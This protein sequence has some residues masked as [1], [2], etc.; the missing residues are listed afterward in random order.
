MTNTYHRPMVTSSMLSTALPTHTPQYSATPVLDADLEGTDV[1]VRHLDTRDDRQGVKVNING[2]DVFGFHFMLVEHCVNGLD[3]NVLVN[4]TTKAKGIMSNYRLGQW[5]QFDLSEGNSG[6]ALYITSDAG[7]ALPPVT[8]GPYDYT[9]KWVTFSYTNRTAH[10]PARA[11]AQIT[12]C[13]NNVESVRLG[14]G[15]VLH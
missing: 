15:V 8:V 14:I 7:K 3:G 10:P 5:P 6:E 13:L 9:T 4:T 12:P 11:R 2:T 1:K